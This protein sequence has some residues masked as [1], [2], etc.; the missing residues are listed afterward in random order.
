[1]L[2]FFIISWM[3][4]HLG[5]NPDGAGRPPVDSKVMRMWV[6]MMDILFH[7]CDN[8]NMVVVEL[9]TSIVNVGIPWWLRW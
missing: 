3:I 1:M 9:H 8:D 2:L 5:M 7:M 4:I 6:V